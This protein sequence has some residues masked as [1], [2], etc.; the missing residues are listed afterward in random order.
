MDRMRQTWLMHRCD[1]KNAKNYHQCTTMGM[2]SLNCYVF[3]SA[4]FFYLLIQQLCSFASFQLLV[5]DN[6]T[7]DNS[8][9][10][11]DGGDL[12][13]PGY[14]GDHHSWDST[15]DVEKEKLSAKGITL[16]IDF[17]SFSIILFQG[18]AT[19][20]DKIIYCQIYF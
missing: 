15:S 13:H 7:E 16:E 12:D 2:P 4:S 19:K 18:L 11:S 1:E 9:E 8:N 20:I 14:Y 10:S 6:E 17:F 3:W 5:L